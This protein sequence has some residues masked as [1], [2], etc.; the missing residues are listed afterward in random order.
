MATSTGRD[1]SLQSPAV[2]HTRSQSWWR[3]HPWIVPLLRASSDAGLIWVAFLAA[4]WLRY[5]REIGGDVLPGFSQP[6]DFFVGK[7]FML[8]VA[9]V[10]IFQLR[11]LYRL[12]RWAS[13]LDEASI[14]ASG[15][16][17]AMAIVILYSFL[18][19][20]YPSRLIFIY[21]WLIMIAL[22]ITKRVITR[23]VRRTL[24][25][26]GHGIERVVI[27]GTGQAG[28]RFMQ[29]I[30]NSPHIGYKLI[31][32]VD[33]VPL[34]ENWSL[35]TE[36]RVVRPSY[37][38]TLEEIDT[39]VRE[40][41]IDQVIIALPS[42]AH[43]HVMPII[44][45]CRELDVGFM[46]VPDLFELTLDRVNTY[47]VGGLP[48]IGLKSA[49]IG[50]WNYAVK[51]A[52]DIVIALA[53]L[54]GT[55]PLL[56]LISIAIKLDSPGPVLFAQERVGKDWRRFICYKFRTMSQDAELL[57]AD[58][59]AAHNAGDLLFKLKDDPRRTRVGRFLRRTSLD[60]FPQFINV[61]LGEMSVVGPRP[62]IPAE[63][64]NYEEWHHRR[65]TVTPGLTGLWQVNGRS[66]LTFDEMVKLDLY[67]A[68]HWSP[69]LDIKLMLRTIPAVLL[70]RGAY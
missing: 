14:I 40:K 43:R 12:P 70:G 2:V 25:S 64:D 27:A 28:Q 33:D 52:M 58:L 35:A 42:T 20:F 22:L 30:F 68:E 39:I 4:Y 57:K 44:E 19:R 63:V 6:F 17:T 29:H 41:R 31:G 9:S 24:W 34:P 67:Y 38:G 47:E 65:L 69:W 62:Q 53:V 46:L 5:E 48:L 37:L 18:Q 8:M 16:T 56:L 10:M 50:G 60:E 36:R 26:R 49:R 66:D 55:S 59:I 21:A 1:V 3:R 61:L 23:L 7:V 54:I 11:G 13:I 45:R 32:M 15:A 51:R